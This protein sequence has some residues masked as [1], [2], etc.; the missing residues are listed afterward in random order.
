MADEGRVVLVLVHVAAGITALLCAAVVMAAGSRQDWGTG[1][2][3]GYVAGVGVTAASAVALTGPGATLPPAVRVLLLV[4]AVLTASAAARGLQLA[5]RPP[6]GRGSAR[7]VQLRLLWGSV[8][9]LV[10]AVAVVSTP[11]GIWVPVIITGVALT[12]CGYQRVKVD[13]AA[14]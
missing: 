10:S 12:E 13:P 11:V 6:T 5:R 9:S 14:S 4:V 3:A 2:G 8:T 7:P 1:W